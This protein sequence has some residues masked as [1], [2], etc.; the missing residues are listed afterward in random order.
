MKLDYDL[1]GS[2]FPHYIDS[3]NFPGWTEAERLWTLTPSMYSGAVSPSMLRPPL[4]PKIAPPTRHLHTLTHLCEFRKDAGSVA[5]HPSASGASVATNFPIWFQWLPVET[6]RPR[7][8]HDRDASGRRTRKHMTPWSQCGGDAAVEVPLVRAAL[9]PPPTCQSSD[10][11]GWP[12]RPG[13]ILVSLRV[14]LILLTL[15]SQIA[16]SYR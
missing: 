10:G 15:F 12:P 5:I 9:L 16:R 14:H 1:W 8:K 3:P 6:V 13:P 7:I 4:A 11:R 2:E